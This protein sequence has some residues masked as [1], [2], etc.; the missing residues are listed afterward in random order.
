MRTLRLAEQT[1]GRQTLHASNGCR[2][3]YTRPQSTARRIRKRALVRTHALATPQAPPAK[4]DVLGPPESHETDVV[5][6]G[7]G[8]GG[9]SC[10]ALLAKYGLR[11]TVL[12]SHSI[13]GGAAHVRTWCL[14]CA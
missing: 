12:E 14:T 4:P 10:A 8:I 5:V 2:A 7:A 6:I 3:G 9:L 1:N 13:L 11:V